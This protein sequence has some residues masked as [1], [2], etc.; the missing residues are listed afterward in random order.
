MGANTSVPFT[1]DENPRQNIGNYKPEEILLAGKRIGLNADKIKS[2]IPHHTE[3]VEQI[4]NLQAR[5]LHSQLV[6]QYGRR[7]QPAG[8]YN[9]QPNEASR[10]VVSQ[11]GG[12]KNSSGK[13]KTSKKKTSK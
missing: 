7:V 5:E 2:I 8:P 9:M 10:P 12:K 1:N 13:R 3:I 11:Y 4:A 6:K